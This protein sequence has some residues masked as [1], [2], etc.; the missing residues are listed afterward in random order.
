MHQAKETHTYHKH[1][2]HVAL[3]HDNFIQC[4]KAYF[5]TEEVLDISNYKLS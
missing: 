1:K 2:E 4:R 3:H 5:N